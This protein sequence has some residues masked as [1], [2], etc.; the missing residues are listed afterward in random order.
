MQDI[1]GAIKIV[2]ANSRS[3]RPLLSSPSF[4][5]GYLY[6]L[7]RNRRRNTAAC[8]RPRSREKKKKKVYWSFAH[9]RARGVTAAITRRPRF[10]LQERSRI[11]S[12][13]AD[14]D[15]EF[16]RD[17]HGDNAPGGKDNAPGNTGR[18]G[19]ITRCC[20]FLPGVAESLLTPWDLR[21]NS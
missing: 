5:T 4:I 7:L 18:K 8:E 16:P 6:E 19:M 9:G 11:S 15:E 21:G 14:E 13:A 10:R 20:S 17:F 3:R 2:F 1:C 12:R